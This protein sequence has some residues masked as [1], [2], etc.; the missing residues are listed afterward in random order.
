MGKKA[1]DAQLRAIR[2]YDATNTKQFHLKLNLKTDAE[3]I[4]HLQAQESIQGY[5]KW[6]IKEDM[7]KGSGK[8]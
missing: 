2:K 1:S 3:I 4:R 7:K 5:I 6:L 8:P